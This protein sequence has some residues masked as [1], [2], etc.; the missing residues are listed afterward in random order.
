MRINQHY[1]ILLPEN[2][3]IASKL[4]FQE[5]LTVRNEIKPNLGFKTE[6]HRSKELV[7]FCLQQQ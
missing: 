4:L 2:G 6:L 3:F 7:K 1:V 5:A